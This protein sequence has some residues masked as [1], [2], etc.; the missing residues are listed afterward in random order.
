MRLCGRK[1]DHISSKTSWTVKMLGRLAIRPERD[2]DEVATN[3][4]PWIA[5]KDL[6]R[7]T[8]ELRLRIANA[9]LG[10]REGNP[11]L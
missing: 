4:V 5:S 1:I 9:T 11:T 10:L 6:S 8:E 2:V 7:L 3:V